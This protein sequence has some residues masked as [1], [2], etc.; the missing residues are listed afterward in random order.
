[1]SLPLLCLKADLYELR[2]LEYKSCAGTI[3]TTETPQFIFHLERIDE[4]NFTVS[5][6]NS[7]Q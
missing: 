3:K 5:A 4:T 6:L 1:M 2:R 7:V